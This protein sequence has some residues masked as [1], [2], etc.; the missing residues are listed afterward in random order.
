VQIGFTVPGMAPDVS[1][2]TVA[3]FARGAEAAGAHSVWVTDRIMDRTP[4]PFVMLGAIAALTTRVRIGTSVLLGSLRP[5]MLVAKSTASIDWLSNG[6]LILGLGVGSR[7]ED[8][9]ATGTPIRERGRRMDELIQVLKLAWRGEPIAFEGRHQSLSVGRLGRL[10]VQAGGPPLWFGGRADA[11][12][13]RVAAVGD[14]YIGS[15]SSGVRG[16]S[17]AWSTI[18]RYAAEA[19]RDP[20]RITPAALIHFSLDSDRERAQAAMREY[21]TQSYGPERAKELGNMVGNADDLRRGLDEY[22]QVG[23]QVLILSSVSADVTH[24]DRFCQEVMPHLRVRV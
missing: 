20:S 9:E 23:V 24:L 17:A 14:G 18:Q 2:A 6:R 1:P 3:E 16:F 8:F 7:S 11:V 21:L 5:P 4:D 13:R 10:P 22:A 15:T 19:G 12:L